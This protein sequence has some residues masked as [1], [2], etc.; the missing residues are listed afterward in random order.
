MKETKK[1]DL[2]MCYGAYIFLK[3]HNKP[4]QIMQVAKRL[5]FV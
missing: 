2:K 4:N 1:Q 5:G 3:K